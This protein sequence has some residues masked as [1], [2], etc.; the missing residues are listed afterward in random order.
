M[1]FYWKKKDVKTT[2]LPYFKKRWIIGKKSIYK[3]KKNLQIFPNAYLSN[4]FY[5][6]NKNENQKSMSS[7]F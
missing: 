4:L 3:N 7:L 1:C 5:K 2:S 6:S